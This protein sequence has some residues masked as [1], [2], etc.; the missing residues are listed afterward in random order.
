[1]SMRPASMMRRRTAGI[2]SNACPLLQLHVRLTEVEPMVW[3]RVLV[4]ADADFWALHVAINDAMGWQDRHLHEF[5]ARH[6]ATGEM[7]RIGL[8]FEDSLDGSVIP[9][10]QVPAV[11]YLRQTGYL[12]IYE[13]DF[14]DG[15]THEVTFE[16]LLPANPRLRLP[17]CTGGE[18]ACPPEDCGG[19]HGYELLREALADA[20]HP[21]HR[22][23]RRW[24]GKRFDPGAFDPRKVRFRDAASAF[25]RMAAD[26]AR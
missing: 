21:E 2:W 25:A 15:W 9:G 3:R 4:S 7:A 18:R 16:S 6:P 5:R 8:P 20:T 24:V 22:A 17:R 1:M 14:G 12:M 10:W 13:Y 26:V 11:E 23:M 19:S